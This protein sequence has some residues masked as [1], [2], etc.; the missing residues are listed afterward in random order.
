VERLSKLL[1]GKSKLARKE[2][3]SRVKKNPNIFF[4]P[5]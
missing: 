5:I 4:P 3:Q 2:I 1:E